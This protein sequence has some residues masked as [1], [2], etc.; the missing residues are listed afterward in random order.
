MRHPTAAE[1]LELHFGEAK[2]TRAGRLSAHASGC[3]E[4]ARLLADL[5]WAERLL[6]V[7]P[8]V[9]PPQDGLERVMAAVAAL[10]QPPRRATGRV[11][12]VL[13]SAVAVLA[14]GFALALGGPAGGA[15]FFAAGCLVT[16]SLAPMLILE[17]RNEGRT[18][19]TAAR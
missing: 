15:V 18:T 10:R 9:R 7:A 4:C 5:A 11:A 12:A 1:L 17:G 3:P 2:G 19:H 14:G 13:P 8:Q 6:A 16:L